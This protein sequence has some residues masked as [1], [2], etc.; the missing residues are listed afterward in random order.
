MELNTLLGLR[1]TAA[2]R[3]M[4]ACYPVRRHM[5]SHPGDF[6]RLLVSLFLTVGRALSG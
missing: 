3:A 5:P 4:L 6:C 1:L 2:S